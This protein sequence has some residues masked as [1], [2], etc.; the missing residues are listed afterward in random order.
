[1]NDSASALSG[2]RI[3]G[4]GSYFPGPALDRDAVVAALDRFDDGLRAEEHERLLELSGVR[5]RHY[6]F[7]A[8]RG[9]ATDCNAS[10]AAAAGRAAMDAAGWQP[11][12]VDL[13]VVTTVV[14]DALMP[15]TSTAVQRRLGIE[16]CT[17][18]EISANCTAPTKGLAFAAG[19]VRL[20]LARR[21]LVCNAQYVSFMFFEP[22]AN[23]AAMTPSQAHLRWHLSDGAG[24]IALEA[25]EPSIDPRFLLTSTGTDLP[26]GMSIPL[27]ASAPD[28][29]AM[30]GDGRQHA[31]QPRL[32]ALKYGI[33]KA[34]AGIER[35]LREIELP[36][37]R[38]D[39]F[40]PS[41]SSVQVA[42]VMKSRLAGIGLRE[43]TWRTN[44]ESVGYVGS[45]A[46][47]IMLDELARRRALAPGDIICTAAEES[48]QWMF[49]G[50]VLRWNP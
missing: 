20:G 21:A 39:H 8:S 35:M 27:G 19:Q 5:G 3:A 17:E 26:S 16:D 29:I 7:D 43:E 24:A 13:L 41:V 37:D 34:T 4:T 12:D 14:P 22:W 6:A 31:T 28:L 50:S 47:P 23:P 33:R 2:V 25:G 1:M 46:V 42:R 9:C 15:P 49:A 10:M 18:L 36:P 32:R 44:F 40:I 30:H 45:V 48:S 11:A 38:V